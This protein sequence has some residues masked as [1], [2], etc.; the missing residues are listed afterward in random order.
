MKQI[1]LYG[2]LRAR[3]GPRFDLD[4]NS[5]AEAIRHLCELLPGFRKLLEDHEAG[6]RVRVGSESLADGDL[7]LPG[8]DVIRLVPCTIG[9]KSAWG[10]ILTGVVLLAAVYF[11]GGALAPWVATFATSV[12]TSL[13]L[14]GAAQLLAGNPAY[15]QGSLDRGPQDTPSYA[16][17]GPHMTT[18]QGNPVPLGYGKLRIS[19]ALVSLGVSPETWTVKGLGGLAPDE[20]GTQGGDGDT[21][22]WVWA[23]A[24]AT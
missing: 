17:S 9:A 1:R 24:P 14:G 21:N 18:G 7:N 5:P 22:P 13:V 23:L 4:V 3:F 12:G 11:S 10:Q 15:T 20:V 16:F 2:F 8:G 19:G 6:F